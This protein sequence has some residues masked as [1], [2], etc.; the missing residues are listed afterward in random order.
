MWDFKGR[1]ESESE[2]VLHFG[3]TCGLLVQ[4]GTVATSGKTQNEEKVMLVQ[5]GGL[6]MARAEP[7]GQAQPP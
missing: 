6:R 1:C 2:T 7:G 4:Y 5:D 3:R